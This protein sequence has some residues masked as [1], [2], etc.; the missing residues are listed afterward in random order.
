MSS[1]LASDANNPQFVG[2][3]NPD[4]ALVVKFYS[5]AVHQP[6]KSEKEGRPIYE[7]VDYI[8]IFT[9]GNQLNII[10]TPVRTEHR[11]RFAQQWAHYQ[12]GKGS[13]MEMGTPV[14]QWPFLSAAQAE[15]FRAVKFF[16]VEQL[17]NAAA[18]QLQ[19][20]GMIGGMNPM[21]IRERAKAF[22]GQAAAGA[23]AGAQAQELVEMKLKYEAL[24][25]QVQA[26]LGAGIQPV[27]PAPEKRKR[28]TKEEMA[29]AK[30]VTE[31]PPEQ[32]EQPAA[33]PV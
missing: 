32:P 2:A 26:M 30:Q 23:P 21:V 19:S 7:D 24:E 33:E 16:T 9:P 13:G 11:A 1:V 31:A 8:Q 14:N 29:A 15:E 18:V 20:L 4:A 12:A 6:F 10:D 3:H 5:K 27:A 28:R 25:K 17:A 22:L